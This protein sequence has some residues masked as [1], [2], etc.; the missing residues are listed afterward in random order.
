M[1]DH[2]I[3]LYAATK[4]TNE[5]MARTYGYLH[6]LPTTGLRFFPVY[7]PWDR[8]DTMLCLFTRSIIGGKSI[9]VI[10]DGKV[11]RN[12]IY[13]D[14]V[15]EGV[16][17]ILDRISTFDINGQRE[18][19]GPDANVAL[20]RIHNIGNNNPVRAID[21]IEAIEC[22]L[23]RRAKIEFMPLEG[24]D[25]PVRYA[26]LDKKVGEISLKT[27]TA[28]SEGIEKFVEWYLG[29]YNRGLCIIFRCPL[30]LVTLITEF[31]D[32]LTQIGLQASEVGRFL[33]ISRVNAGRHA[34]R[35]Q[36]VRLCRLP[37]RWE[38]SYWGEILSSFNVRIGR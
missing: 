6:N 14:D 21:C 8:P 11:E 34:E 29:Y 28:I 17:K 36:K 35:G 23:G 26:N 3:S 18:A 20:H 16:A 33:S 38:P 37:R 19:L 12:Y 9:Q 24:S 27:K 32:W 7:G 10:G 31:F 4:K 22:A 25:V 1:F 30:F 15:V 2:P 5:L 13:V